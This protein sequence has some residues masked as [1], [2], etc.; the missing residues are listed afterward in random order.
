MTEQNNLDD[1]KVT[2]N[3]EDYLT[4]IQLY[5]INTAVVNLLSALRKY[6]ILT[7]VQM[8][9]VNKSHNIQPLMR[10][11]YQFEE[12]KMV[13]DIRKEFDMFYVY[14]NKNKW[15]L[16]NSETLRKKFEQAI[17]YITT[18]MQKINSVLDN[19]YT[20][21]LDTFC[22]M[23]QQISTNVASKSIFDEHFKIS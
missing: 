15:V 3:R 21:I 23:L 2:E 5:G 18:N 22:D 1:I 19:S 16:K 10:E 9:L 4:D 13:M 6:T 11:I 7:Q 17:T 20:E 14:A 8:E 12:I